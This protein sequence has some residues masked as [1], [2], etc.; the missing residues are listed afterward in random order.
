MFEASDE[1]DCFGLA[2]GFLWMEEVG[3][4]SVKNDFCFGG[5]GGGSGG[6]GVAQE[7]AADGYSFELGSQGVQQGSRPMAEMVVL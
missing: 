5:D 7:R 6:E 1:E 4:D 2:E 3:V